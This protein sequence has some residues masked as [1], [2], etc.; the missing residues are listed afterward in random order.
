MGPCCTGDCATRD[1]N[2]KIATTLSA[3]V[4]GSA[5]LARR[6][7]AKSAVAP[8]APAAPSRAPSRAITPR[9]R[10]TRHPT[11]KHLIRLCIYE[12]PGICHILNHPSI[13]PNLERCLGFHVC[14]LFSSSASRSAGFLH[15]NRALMRL[16]LGLCIE[17]YPRISNKSCREF[18]AGLVLEQHSGHCKH[19]KRVR[20][21]TV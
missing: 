11:S 16:L 21:L 3:T 4:L 9:P 1:A 7:R 19:E 20:E 2:R 15:A 10:P 17:N 8:V 18:K 12:A 5:L 14:C 6:K 13:S